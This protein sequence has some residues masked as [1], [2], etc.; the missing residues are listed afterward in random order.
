MAVALA[1]LVGWFL[2]RPLFWRVSDEQVAL[3]LEEHEPSLQAE[4][5]S[6]IEASRLA[7]TDNSPHSKVLVQ[8]PGRS[9]PS[10]SARRST[11]A[12]TS[13]ASRSGGMPRR[14]P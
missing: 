2:V 8:P 11:G 1:S 10:P 14:S 4:I 9:R 12:A 7:E 6:A 5:I 13:S 3:Y